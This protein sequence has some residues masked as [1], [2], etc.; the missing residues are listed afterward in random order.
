VA[1]KFGGTQEGPAHINWSADGG[2]TWHHTAIT[3][4]FLPENPRFTAGVAPTGQPKP[5]G[6]PNVVYFCA[7]TNVGFTSPAIAGRVCFRSFDGGSTWKRGALLFTGTVPQHPEC[8][9]SGETY[10]AIDGNYPQAARGGAL[11]VMVSC[12]GKSYL[13][14]SVDEAA[15]FPIIHVAGKPLTL[16]VPPGGGI[17]GG[18]DFRVGP[19]DTMYLMYQTGSALLLRVSRN[20]GLTW[21]K[22]YNAV[23]PGVH[24]V[25]KWSFASGGA[26]QVAVAYL[27]QHSGQKTWDGYVTETKNARAAS[28]PGPGPVFFSGRVNAAS[29]PL[30][31]GNGI[32]GSGYIGLPKNQHVPFPPPFNNQ[33][34][35]NDFIGSTIAFDGNAWGSFTQDCGPSPD[36]SGCQAQADQTRGFAGYLNWSPIPR[37]PIAPRS[38]PNLA[39]TGLAIGVPITAVILIAAALLLATRT[40]RRP[41]P[42]SA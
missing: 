37:T 11:F 22:P 14:R 28:V 9:S 12:G 42:L 21:S 39:A 26:S 41:G 15:S 2:A 10:T 20:F 19:D 31:Y 35:G 33:S 29:R 32:Q 3:T 38:T 27:G 6:Y 25:S 4:L 40:R 30:L 34:T 24:A 36:S 7:N 23:A 16:P 1:P 8:G 13:A 17:G 18:A 5:H